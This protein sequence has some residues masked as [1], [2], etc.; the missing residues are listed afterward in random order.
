MALAWALSVTALAAYA[1]PT[2]RVVM[3]KG[4]EICVKQDRS[5]LT[6]FPGSAVGKSLP[7]WSKDG[8]K[9]AY[10]EAKDP[11]FALASLV[12]IDQHGQVI[13]TMPIKPNVPGEV[14]SGMRFVES[15]E[16]LTSDSVVVS[17]T[18]NPSTTEYNVFDLVTGKP[19]KEFFDDGGGAA[20]SPDGRHF[21]SVSGGPH[22]T[23]ESDRDHKLNVDGTPVFDAQGPNR[24]QISFRD[25]PK[26]SADGKSLVVPA[27]DKE[28][29]S[30]S[31]VHWDA[32][33]KRASM[34]SLPFSAAASE[35]FFWKG[36]S[37]YVKRKVVE[38]RSGTTSISS[39]APAPTVKGMAN[40]VTEAWVLSNNAASRWKKVDASSAVNP[41][42]MARD[43]RAQLRQQNRTAETKDPDFWCADCE[44]TKLPRRASLRD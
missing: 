27:F 28:K 19:S 13:Q 10:I 33:S 2:V 16:W 34:I 8:T 40:T 17:G 38:P 15:V 4:T 11:A 18:V 30:N 35:E 22:F 9:I 14:Q 6:C 24:E 32:R 43:F 1:A 25:T 44:L 7:V 37:L 12:V 42:A 5:P 23:L 29:R 39:A 20:F 21:A 3:V 36:A 41:A 26:W 31:M